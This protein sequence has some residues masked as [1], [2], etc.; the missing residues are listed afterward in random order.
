MSIKNLQNKIG[1]VADGAF[2][3]NTFRAA[4]KFYGL[5]NEQAVHFF[6]QCAHESAG[7]KVFIENLNYS[8]T[9][10]LSVFGK[11]FDEQRASSYARHPERIAN[12]VYANR[13][14]NGD[15]ASG[16][17][18]KF[19]GRGAIQLTGKNNYKKFGEHV[20]LNFSVN[21][22]LV[23]TNYAFESALYFFTSNNLFAICVDLEEATIKKLTKRIN[24]GY[25]GLE[26]RIELTKKYAAYI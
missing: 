10:L 12:K 21:P 6:A 1:V 26:H 16:D 22:G 19:R 3:P 20:N 5:T 13:M 11:Y 25:N 4:Q 9:A 23:E 18:W 8:K 7:F 17:G 24:G 14:G 2:G 15:E